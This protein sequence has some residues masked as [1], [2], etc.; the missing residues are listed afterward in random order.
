VREGI[1]T[2]ANGVQHEERGDDFYNCSL[3]IEREDEDR[4]HYRRAAEQSG[5]ASLCVL[6][7]SP[8]RVGVIEGT[9]TRHSPLSCLSRRAIPKPHG[10][11]S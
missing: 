1:V 4:A 9:T 3:R 2:L 7:R 10:P 8:E 11:A 6:M 5:N